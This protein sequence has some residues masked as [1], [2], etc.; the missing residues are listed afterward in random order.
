MVVI[1]YNPRVQGG[2]QIERTEPFLQA[3]TLIVRGAHEALSIR[4]TLR[5]IVAGKELVV[6]A[7]KHQPPGAITAR[8]RLYRSV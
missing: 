1:G 3:Q 6:V 8:F 5:V 7:R 2:D 4:I